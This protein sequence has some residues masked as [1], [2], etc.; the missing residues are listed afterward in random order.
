MTVMQ[1][2]QATTAQPLDLSQQS[3]IV[4]KEMPEVQKAFVKYSEGCNSS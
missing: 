1:T 4:L 2:R 3:T